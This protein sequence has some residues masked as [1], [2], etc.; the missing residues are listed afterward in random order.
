M[1]PQSSLVLSTFQNW[2]RQ[3]D[4]GKYP[5]HQES[6]KLTTFIT[7]FGRFCFKRLPFGIT[8]APEI[9]QCLMTDLLKKEEGCEAIMDDIIVY[10][11][12]AEEHDENL[13]K[14]C[15]SLRSQD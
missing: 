6:A 12:S 7:P 13:H 2:M 3:V 5:L 15:K 4:S 11:K 1:L 9:F 14:N 8:C 10:G